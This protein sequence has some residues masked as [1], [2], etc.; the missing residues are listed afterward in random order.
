MSRPNYE[1]NVP[2]GW[3]RMEEFCQPG[4]DSKAYKSDVSKANVHVVNLYDTGAWV[5]NGED[6]DG[7]TFDERY[8]DYWDALAH[9]RGWMLRH[10]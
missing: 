1:L 6:K 5:V 9:A 3:H 4:K 7:N 2:E 8:N 10:D